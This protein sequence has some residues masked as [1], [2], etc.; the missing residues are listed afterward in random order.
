[1]PSVAVAQ[2][3]ARMHYAVPRIFQSAGLLER[4]YTDFAGFSRRPGIPARRVT[5]FPTLGIGYAMS[6]RLARSESARYRCWLGAGRRFCASILSH[7]LGAATAVYGFNSAC[8]ELLRAAQERGVFRIMEQTSAAKPVERRLLAEEA[9]AWPEWVSGPP[10]AGPAAEFAAREAAEWA[11]ADVILCGSEWA[12]SSVAAAGGPADR[13]RVVPY[14][15]DLTAVPREPR[16]GAPL[17]VLFCGAVN[18]QKGVPYLLEAAR[19]LDPRRVQFR[20]VGSIL[21]P[22]PV[23][24]AL[25]ARCHLAGRVPRGAMTEHYGW[26]D[27]LLMPSICEGSATVCYEA[28]ASGLP[29]IATPN[30]G[31]VVRHGVEG[32]LVP[33]RSPEA[34]AEKLQLL[35]DA[36]AVLAA[37]S[38]NAAAR[39]REFTVQAYAARLLEACSL[40]V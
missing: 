8:L 16:R 27:V 29:V 37:L 24:A 7:G 23:R 5:H 20:L 18:A 35:A 40:P 4:L 26:A 32:F 39:S 17:R 6:L 25:R 31:S 21:A 30:A 28:L 9:E 33:I 1:M 19:R 38:R 15:V 13:C 10:P 34:I 11:A 2:L 3:G 12:R 22:E 14:G 36:P